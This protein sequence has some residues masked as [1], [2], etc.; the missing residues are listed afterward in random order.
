MVKYQDI[1]KIPTARFHYDSEA[2][3]FCT[4]L[5]PQWLKEDNLDLNPDFQR[6]HVWSERDQ[7]GYIEYLLKGGRTAST[8]CFN[9]PQWNDWTEVSKTVCLDGLQR[10]TALQKFIN[11]ELKAFGYYF[12]NFEDWKLIKRSLKVSYQVFTFKT[13]REILQFYLTLNTCGVKH[14]P[15]EI[16]RVSKLLE[17]E[18]ENK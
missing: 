5:I 1:E 6:G 12:K 14:S 8:F 7:V 15:E 3:Y 18:N 10:I 17:Q 9:N 4:K 13:R 2:Y 16:E 11:N